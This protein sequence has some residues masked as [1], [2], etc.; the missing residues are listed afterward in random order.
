MNSCVEKNLGCV[1]TI[2]D[3]HNGHV[4][5]F[6]TSF[7]NFTLC[8]QH[9]KSVHKKKNEREGVKDGGFVKVSV[10]DLVGWMHKIMHQ[11]TAEWNEEKSMDG[12]ADRW[13]DGRTDEQSQIDE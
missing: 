8:L 5:F 9:D 2:S 4:D 11:R 10:L 13:M 7:Q 12:W 6:L 1:L 3:H